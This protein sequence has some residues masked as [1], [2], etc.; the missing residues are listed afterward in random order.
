MTPTDDINELYKEMGSYP[1]PDNLPT[2]TKETEKSPDPAVAYFNIVF[3]HYKEVKKGLPKEK[4]AVVVYYG[5]SGNA[6][7]IID[8]GYQPPDLITLYAEDHRICTRYPY[9]Q[10]YIEIKDAEKR[11]AGFRIQEEILSELA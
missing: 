7:E 1:D 10:M 6:S 4:Q 11:R 9:V 2:S 3:K 8:V 5:P